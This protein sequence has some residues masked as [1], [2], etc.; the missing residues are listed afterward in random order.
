MY[1]YAGQAA[2]RS[3]RGCLFATTLLNDEHCTRP[4]RENEVSGIVAGSLVTV[5]WFLWQAKVGLPGKMRIN[6]QKESAMQALPL[7]GRRA[8][9]NLPHVVRHA[10]QGD[11]RHAPLNAA[12]RTVKISLPNGMTL[13]SA[14]EDFLLLLVRDAR[15]CIPYSNTHRGPATRFNHNGITPSASFLSRRLHHHWPPSDGGACRGQLL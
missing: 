10:L 9:Q 5:P 11:D 7:F 1:R 13:I 2:V 12:M 15:T 3:S 6:A 8:V 4:V 14:S